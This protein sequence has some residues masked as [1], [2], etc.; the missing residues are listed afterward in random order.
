V[1][2]DLDLNQQRTFVTSHAK[3]VANSA[4]PGCR[5]CEIIKRLPGMWFRLLTIHVNDDK[6]HLSHR[7]N[8][9]WKHCRDD[10]C[11]RAA[12]RMRCFH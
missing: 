5:H 1:G 3:S 11:F 4:M 10:V 12:A 7:V 2:V 6:Q 9:I 8:K